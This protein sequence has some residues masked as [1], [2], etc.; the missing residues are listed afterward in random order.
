MSHRASGAAQ[1]LGTSRRHSSPP[2][3]ERTLGTDAKSVPANTAPR[4]PAN[5]APA[6]SEVGRGAAEQS[7]APRCGLAWPGENF[8]PKRGALAQTPLELATR[9]RAAM[10][11]LVVEDD[12][13]AAD[14]IVRAFREVGHVADQAADGEDGL[15]LALEREYDVLIV[16]RMLPKRDG[17][18]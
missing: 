9:D 5:V 6:G 16:D 12:R 17:L 8:D 2:P 15:A 1:V 10:R 14:Y 7:A 13:D 3:A 4:H 11:L 18:S